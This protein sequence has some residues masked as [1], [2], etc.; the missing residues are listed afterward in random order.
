M[1]VDAVFCDQSRREFN[2][3][4]PVDLLLG[5]Y[6][7]DLQCSAAAVDTA[8]GDT[9]HGRHTCLNLTTHA[10]RTLRCLSLSRVQAASNVQC[11]STV[12]DERASSGQSVTEPFIPPAG[13]SLVL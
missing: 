4:V 12:V 6:L 8:A 13:E 7:K 1:P 3:F 11:L 2:E 5:P 10:F 9:S